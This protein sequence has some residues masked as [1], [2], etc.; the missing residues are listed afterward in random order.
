MS[1]T[2]RIYRTALIGLGEIAEN[3]HM[4]ALLDHPRFRL[5]A[6]C[7]SSPDRRA[8]L[9]TLS[10]G[11]PAFANVSDL[12][13]HQDIDVAVLALHPEVSVSIAIDF[14]KKGKSI[15]DEKPLAINL[16]ESKTLGEAVSSAS[17]IYQIGFVFRY[18]SFAMEIKRLLKKIGAP[19]SFIITISDERFDDANPNHFLRLQHIIRT[20]SAINHEGSHFLDLV[21][22]WMGSDFNYVS[23][24]A[25]SGKTDPSFQGPNIWHTTLAGNDECLLQ[26]N[27]YWLSPELGDSR[28][29]V[30]GT[31]GVLDVSFKSGRGELLYDGCREEVLI[32][33]LAQN[34]IGQLDAFAQSLDTGT[35]QG[36]TFQDGFSALCAASACETAMSTGTRV[37][38]SQGIFPK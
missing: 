8:R 11:V 29:R 1:Q 2:S 37:S 14:L 19:R 35:V 17:G 12:Y 31:H 10:Q 25:S 18:S 15:L 34:W 21:K 27:V 6:L 36:A 30:S 9:T 13:E 32:P 3:G 26:L 28:L 4:P 23:A 5:V 38:I 24:L 20:S 7:D 22:F 16:A 33:K